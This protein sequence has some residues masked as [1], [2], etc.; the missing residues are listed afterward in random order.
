MKKLVV[1]PSDPMDAYIEKGFSFEHLEDYYN[2]GG[3]FDEVYCLSP[4]KSTR[5]TFGKIKCIQARPYQFKKIIKQIK[6]NVVRAYGGYWCADWAAI[7][8]VKGIPTV[9]S[10]HDTNPRLIYDS[11]RYADAI[12]C[13]SKSVKDAAINL[14]NLPDKNIWIMPNRI[15]TDLFS[16]K[17]SNAKA[18]ELTKRFGEGKHLLHVGRKVEQKNLDTVIKAL[19]VLDDSYKAIFVGKGDTAQYEQLAK[20]CGV[21]DRCYFVESVPNDELPYWYSWCDCMCTPSRW[22]G[23]GLVFIEAAACEAA[24]VTSNVGPMNEYLNRENAVLVDDYENPAAIADAIRSV[25]ESDQDEIK[26]IRKNARAVGLRFT[27]EAVDRQEIEIYQKVMQMGPKDRK[28]IPVKF[29]WRY[30]W[31][32][33]K[34]IARHNLSEKIP[35]NSPVRKVYRLLKSAKRAIKN[36]L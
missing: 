11:V 12:V 21:A 9:V 28:P 16:Y 4:W 7:S 2:P 13:M 34:D 33:K 26:K 29:S 15:D 1:F 18:E 22:E 27:K 10:L 35:S 3:Y 8:K 17:E 31:N 36:G 5:E 25:L 23:F 6:P 30:S 24:I 32:E 14:L 20:E 19:S